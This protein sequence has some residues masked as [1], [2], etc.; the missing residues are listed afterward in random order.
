MIKYLKIMLKYNSDLPLK[1][2][3]KY[4]KCKGEFKLHNKFYTYNNNNNLLNG[5]AR[6]RRLC[7]SYL[8]N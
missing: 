8:S 6:L 4:K 5:P 1:L 3:Y 2:I 7:G